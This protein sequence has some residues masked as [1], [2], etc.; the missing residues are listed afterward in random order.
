M[1]KFKNAKT[2][3]HPCVK[4]SIQCINFYEIHIYWICFCG[5]PVLNLIQIWWKM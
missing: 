4:Y 5:H 3:L 2:H 1:V